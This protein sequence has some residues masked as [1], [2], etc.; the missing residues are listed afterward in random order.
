MIAHEAKKRSCPGQSARR[1]IAFW[2]DASAPYPV[3]CEGQPFAF[4]HR[5]MC[6]T[7][8]IGIRLWK[9]VFLPDGKRCCSARNDVCLVWLS[10]AAGSGTTVARGPGLARLEEK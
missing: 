2:I 1:F 7:A 5:L 9:L 6:L 4:D 8:I 3:G 10:L